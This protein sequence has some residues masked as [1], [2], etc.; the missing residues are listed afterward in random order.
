VPPAPD[1]A[2]FSRRHL[3]RLSSAAAGSSR[4]LRLGATP[5][6]GLSRSESLF[7]FCVRLSPA[8]SSVSRPVPLARFFRSAPRLDPL[9]VLQFGPSSRGV[10]VQPSIPLVHVQGSTLPPPPLAVWSSIAN[11]NSLTNL[12]L[13]EFLAF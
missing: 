7:R 2:Y 8:S 1:S 4:F 9:V 6:F 12:L 11:L 10:V 3:S 13:F 5:N